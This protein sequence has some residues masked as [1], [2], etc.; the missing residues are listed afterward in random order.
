MV[1]FEAT[2]AE[3][4]II[5]KIV[6]RA[7]KLYKKNDGVPYDTTDAV[8]DIEATHSNGCPLDLKKLLEFDDFNFMHDITG[9]RNC[10]S[11]KTGKLTKN[12]LPRCARIEK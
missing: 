10:I 1:K 3:L 9:I 4:K 7:Q 2:L 11:R 6:T 8:M 12:F 5:K